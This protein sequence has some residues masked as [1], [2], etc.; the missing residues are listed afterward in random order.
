MSDGYVEIL[1]KKQPKSWYALIKGLFIFATIFVIVVLGLMRVNVLFIVLG[2]LLGVAT[3]FV[4][5]ELDLEYEYLYVNGELSVDKIMGRTSRKKC[6]DITLDRVEMIAPL[7]SWHLGS[8]EKQKS[9][10]LDYSSGSENADIYVLY[11][12]SDKGLT[13]LLFEP[14][15]KM[16]ECMRQTAPRKVFFE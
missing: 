7:K 3:Y 9:A 15:A 4:F 2:A 14:N 16:L 8:F 12:R 1:V 13:K 5:Q 6:I 10:V 11:F